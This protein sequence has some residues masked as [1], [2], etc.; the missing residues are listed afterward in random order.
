MPRRLIRIAPW[1]GLAAA[2]VWALRVFASPLG[3]GSGDARWYAMMLA[4]WVTQA[5]G[6]T[7]PVWLGQ[8]EFAFNGAVSPFRVAPLY[9]HWAGALDLLT[10]HCLGIYALQN[11]T[12]L[13]MGAA[14]AWGAFA[15]LTRICP[16]ERL[17][18]A[19]LSAMYLF[20]PGTLALASILDLQ[21]SWAAVP[22]LPWLFAGLW[23]AVAE[24]GSRP[25]WA[26][27]WP[28]AALWWAHPPTA[29][30]A[31]GLAA[32]CLGV[33]WTRGPWRAGAGGAARFLLL[34]GLLMAFTA[35]AQLSL[36]QPGGTSAA[37]TPLAR[38]GLIMDAVRA[39]FPGALLPLSP[40][41]GAPGDDQLGY[42]LWALLLAALA[43][44]LARREFRIAVLAAGLLGLVL[45][46]LPV[47]GATAAAWRA[48]PR[49][50][51][52]ITY[53]WPMQ[54]IYVIVAAGAVVVGFG[55][56]TR[57][58]R[59]PRA[60]AALLALAAIGCGWS[61][62]EANVIASAA[63]AR[64]M[65]PEASARS[66][67]PENRFL[68]RFAYSQ[69]PGLPQRFS[70][71]VMEP[72][73][74]FRLVDRRTGEAVGS[75]GPPERAWTS[76][77]SAGDGDG[78]WTSRAALALEPGRDYL[79]EVDFPRDDYSGILQLSGRRLY[80]E[81]LLP[82]SGE[83]LA[84]GCARG[85]D[86]AIALRIRGA[87]REDARVRFITGASARPPEP[88]T[89]RLWARAP[90]DPGVDLIGLAPAVMTV[91]SPADALVLTPRM[92]VAGYAAAVDGRPVAAERL[93]HGELAIPVPA[94]E[95]RVELAYAAPAYLAAAYW[96]SLATA[97]AGG[98]AAA[99]RRRAGGRP[100]ATGRT[101]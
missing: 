82:R 14:G 48:M 94:G 11:L 1:I 32:L 72:W 22:F 77:W 39:S 24:P 86:H 5:R 7:F 35:A 23:R 91:R 73:N 67:Y 33:A 92:Y 85:C 68:T 49:V 58:I 64:R 6:G 10:G 90:G 25:E 45:L 61:A 8:T 83:A 100:A 36:R 54:R 50:V 69:F 57:L 34:G 51:T 65:P 96:L 76:S 19:L 29:L 41:A 89:F 13:T 84:F 93:G 2:A 46:V 26:V 95:H 30:W 80:R 42:G 71:G 3:V 98:I 18:A 12:V 62:Y 21:M 66:L 16:R 9:Q 78:V 31:T 88:W 28:L 99:R 44:A 47:P 59:G 38:P 15:V 97:L 56:M 43:V 52:R 74:E 4:D 75:R 53:Y 79:L 60:R 55:V 70:S 40:G 87:D 20:S 63:R 27:A 81:Y 37:L 17:L 101:T